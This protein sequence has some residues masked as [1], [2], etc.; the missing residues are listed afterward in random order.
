MS[1]SSGGYN[2]IRVLFKM[3]IMTVLQFDHGTVPSILIQFIWCHPCKDPGG[4]CNVV[5]LFLYPW[6][7]M[8]NTLMLVEMFLELIETFPL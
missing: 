3:A 4:F 1:S 7:I 8:H 2:Y 5:F 6:K